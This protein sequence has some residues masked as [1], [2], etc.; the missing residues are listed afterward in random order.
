MEHAEQASE[1]S[2]AETEGPAV[3]RAA[4][5]VWLVRGGSSNWVIVRDPGGGPSFTL[6][7][8]GYPGDYGRLLTSIGLL[9]L[10][11][12]DCRAA[13][14]THGHVDHIGG[15][16]QLAADYAVPVLCHADEASNLVGPDREQVTLTRI[17]PS[18][19]RGRV[20]RWL[21][22]AL[23]LRALEPVSITPSAVF[24]D[25]DV[26]DVPGSPTVLHFPGHTSGSTAFVFTAG[27]K[28][29]VACGDVAV[30]SHETLPDGSSSARLLPP[31]F[32]HDRAGAEASLARLLSLDPDVLLPGHGPALRMG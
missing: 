17:L 31:M 10:R 24:R 18:L 3:S 29:V 4:E 19:W 27:G 13:L 1:L 32:H 25:G 8:G 20:R 30:T 14:V 12:G 9:G 21:R 15:L 2:R 23:R 26:L 16:Q 6:V 28:R 7:D 11:P 22:L 5:C